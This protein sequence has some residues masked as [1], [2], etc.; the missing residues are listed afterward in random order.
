VGGFEAILHADDLGEFGFMHGIRPGML[1]RGS[2]CVL[3]V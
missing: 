2:V 1:C 3:S